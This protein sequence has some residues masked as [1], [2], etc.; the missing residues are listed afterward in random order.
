MDI[1]YVLKSILREAA[2]LGASGELQCG[3]RLSGAVNGKRGEGYLLLYSEGLVLLYRRLGMRD[4]EGCFADLYEWHFDNYR[5]EKYSLVMDAHC[6]DQ[7][8]VCEF[9]PSERESAELILNALAAAHAEPLTVYDENT[10]LM[11]SVLT[12]FTPEDQ[13]AATLALL[14]KQLYQASYKYAAKHQLTELIDRTG[15]LFSNEQKKSV[16]LNLI[17]L[18]LASDLHQTQFDELLKL[19]GAWDLGDDFLTANVRSMRLRRQLTELFPQ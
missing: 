12:S 4:Y 7:A 11:A 6:R 8:F 14:G 16:L 17:E 2:T 19:S 10:L 5:E 18:Q 13:T 9:T 3:I 15:E 1:K